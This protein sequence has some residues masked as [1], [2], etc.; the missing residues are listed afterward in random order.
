MHQKLVTCLNNHC[1]LIISRVGMENPVNMQEKWCSWDLKAA[2]FC[3]RERNV[4]YMGYGR[5][6]NTGVT[7]EHL[8]IL[9]H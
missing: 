2:T 8:N 1:I 5:G 6:L 7:V 4:G 9:P 3:E